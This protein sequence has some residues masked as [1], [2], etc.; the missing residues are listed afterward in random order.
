MLD[1]VKGLTARITGRKPKVACPECK[2][3]DQ[4]KFG[5]EGRFDRPEA[6]E[7]IKA[8]KL[9]QG[10]GFLTSESSDWIKQGKKIKEYR[11]RNGMT[12]AE[13][14]G[15]YGGLKASE[16]EAIEKG[17]RNPNAFIAFLNQRGVDIETPGKRAPKGPTRRKAGASRD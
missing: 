6:K 10:R 14:A 15:R 11:T 16:L 5:G 12:Q 13:F 17:Y 9:C 4:F 1:Y 2:G 3:V 7:V 8:C